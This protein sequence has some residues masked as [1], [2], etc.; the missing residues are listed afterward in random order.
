V[1]Q[2][3]S[4]ASENSL[5]VAQISAVSI[6]MR[7]FALEA[8]ATVLLSREQLALRLHDIDLHEELQRL[9]IFENW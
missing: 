2:S 5:S 7:R 8:G 3:V 1:L 9:I 4:L 6:A